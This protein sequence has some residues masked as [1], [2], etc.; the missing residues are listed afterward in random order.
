MV[1]TINKGKYRRCMQQVEESED[2]KE[3]QH[4]DQFKL[5]S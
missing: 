3:R 4:I 5:I 1:F 2:H